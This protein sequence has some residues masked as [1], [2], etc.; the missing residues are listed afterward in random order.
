MWASA[1]AVFVGCLFIFVLFADSFDLLIQE[2]CH[3]G[4]DFAILAV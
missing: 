2:T 4:A 1:L 3:T